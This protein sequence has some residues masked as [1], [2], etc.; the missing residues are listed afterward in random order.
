MDEIVSG[1]RLQFVS[2]SEQLAFI[3]VKFHSSFRFPVLKSVEIILE[4]F[5]V[6]YCFNLSVEQAIV[7]EK[8]NMGTWSEPVTNVININ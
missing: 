8:T 6:I 3:G 7:S 4:N 5:S 2:D 1:N